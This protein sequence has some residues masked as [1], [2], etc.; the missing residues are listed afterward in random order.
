M[1]SSKEHEG[2]QDNI[3]KVGYLADAQFLRNWRSKLANLQAHVLDH[4][5]EECT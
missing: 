4:G 3:G 2:E 5:T 1:H